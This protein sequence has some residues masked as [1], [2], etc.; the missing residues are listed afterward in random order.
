MLLSKI[1][2]IFYLFFLAILSALIA[3]N[4]Y[5]CFVMLVGMTVFVNIDVAGHSSQSAACN[6][7]GVNRR[8][9]LG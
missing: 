6:V 8:L 7:F 4:G 5:F 3:I 1:C 2:A 9:R